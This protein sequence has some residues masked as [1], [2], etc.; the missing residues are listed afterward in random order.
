M[1]PG[2]QQA[3]SSFHW[4]PVTLPD[5]IIFFKPTVFSSFLEHPGDLDDIFPHRTS[6]KSAVNRTDLGENRFKHPKREIHAAQVPDTYLNDFIQSIGTGISEDIY[7]NY[8]EIPEP[9]Q[10]RQA[11]G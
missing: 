10:V 1:S 5:A 6:K 8:Q 9:F 2:P 3:M 4:G 7:G 11:G